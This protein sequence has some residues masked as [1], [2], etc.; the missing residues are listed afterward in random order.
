MFLV[1]MS[2]YNLQQA[3][4]DSLIIYCFDAESN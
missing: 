2:S 3:E 4:L 1:F